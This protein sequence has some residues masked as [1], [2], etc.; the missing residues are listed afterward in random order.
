MEQKGFDNYYQAFVPKSDF[1]ITGLGQFAGNLSVVA[2]F[3]KKTTDLARDTSIHELGHNFGL[4]HAPCGNPISPDPDYP[5]ANA[6]LGAGSRF[7]SGF[8]SDSATFVD[9]RDR[10]LHDLMSYCAGDTFSDYHYRKMQINLG[11]AA[12]ETTADPQPTLAQDLLSVAGT[13]A[14]GSLRLRPL[15]MFQGL[16]PAPR[17]GTHVLRV[18]SASGTRD[19]FFTPMAL[20]H[21]ADRFTFALTIPHP[22]SIQRLQVL[23]DG[24]VLFDQQ[25]LSVGSADSEVQRRSAVP[26]VRLSEDND[27]ISAS[28]NADVWPFLSITHVGSDRTMLAQDLQGGSATV[29]LSTLEP[30]G[31][32]E[33]T[34]SD[35]LNSTRV[36]R[37][38]Q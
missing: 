20:D 36:L 4:R 22:G 38:R 12:R 11:E 26:M 37:P 19:H 16:P 28:W 9:A 13:I 31:S 3:A 17:D 5:Y 8:R 14:H 27:R 1:G 10:Q 33:I 23:H 7:I 29:T 34:L 2:D 32:F 24:V 6:A 21:D 35:G 18:S 15:K 30:K 25:Q